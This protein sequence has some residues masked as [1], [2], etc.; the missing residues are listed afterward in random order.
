MRAHEQRQNVFIAR[1]KN[2][3]V[4]MAPLAVLVSASSTFA[5]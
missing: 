3:F 5:E 2:N 4:I 1:N